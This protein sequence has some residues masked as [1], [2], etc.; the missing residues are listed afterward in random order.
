MLRRASARRSRPVPADRV[1]GSR[2]VPGDRVPVF[3]TGGESGMPPEYPE[4]RCITTAARP[5]R[6]VIG[7]SAAEHEF[8]DACGAQGIA[9]VPFFSLAG[10]GRG[11]GFTRPETAEVLAVAQAHRA[12]PAQVRLAWSLHRRPHVLVIPG[13][14][15]PAHLAA[16]VAAAGL[17]L[18]PDEVAR[19]TAVAPRE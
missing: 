15:D 13:T 14:G 3:G 7:A 6:P 4:H 9:F 17:R 18:T 12:T 8:T 10:E 5:A 11:A 2:P 19:L 1:P 16:N